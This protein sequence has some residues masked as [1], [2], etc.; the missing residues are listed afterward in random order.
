VR[1][2][3]RSRWTERETEQFTIEVNR[4]GRFDVWARKRVLRFAGST[5]ETR[6]DTS[7]V[8]LFDVQVRVSYRRRVKEKRRV[9]DHSLS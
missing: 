3:Y 1:G 4:G 2:K 9:I 6:S 5:I 7:N 8:D